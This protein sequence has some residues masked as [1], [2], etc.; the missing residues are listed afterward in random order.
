MSTTPQ[1]P[2][3][4][5]EPRWTRRG[6]LDWWRINVALFLSGYAIF[7]QLYC[8]QPLLPDLARAFS[9]SAAESS[10]A[11]S[12]S[13]G[14]LALA[15]LAAGALSES[16]GRK[17]LMFASLTL[18]AVLEIGVALAPSWPL[19][20][21]L[22]ALEGLALGGAPAVAMAY[23]AEEIEP[24]GLGAAMGLYIGGNAAGG[25]AGRVVTGLVAEHS[26]WR[27]A[28]AVVGGLGL[29]AAL[30]FLALLPASRNFTPRPSRGL[31]PHLAAWG[32]H[33][34]DPSMR[35][36]FAVAF[37]AMGGFVTVYNYI[38]FRL[39]A[40]PFDLGQ[41]AVGAIFVVYLAGIVA[42]PVAGS[43][44]DRFGRAPVLI[45]GVAL[46]ALGLAL[47]LAGALTAIVV[48]IAA[49]TAGFFAAHTVAGGW[50]GA[51][52]KGDKAHASSLYLL[53]YYLGSS[54]MGSLGGLFW[55]DLGWGGVT[56]FVAV[57]LVGQTVL[58]ARLSRAAV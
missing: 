9:V 15:I 7:S 38:G 6:S 39:M 8:V 17:P 5:P 23:L 52:A 26:D 40:P 54:V 22:R 3:V 32:R 34:G 47:T 16:L 49:L 31:A 21:V 1:R 53:A 58:A 50:V 28:L 25:M 48:G 37:L 12:L 43:L 51:R 18:A 44:A 13:T 30:G 29:A 14:S 56:G 36:L 55:T 24:A 45:G 33:L 4:A 42:S 19:V 11:L 41:A 2:D 35:A 10:L 46:S 27:I 20:L 57:L